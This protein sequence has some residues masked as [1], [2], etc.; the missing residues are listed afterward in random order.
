MPQAVQMKAGMS[1]GYRQTARLGKGVGSG[2][3]DALS[4]A[5]TQGETLLR[6]G[7]DQFRISSS[8]CPGFDVCS[9]FYT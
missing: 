7:I 8:L 3:A 1:E 9:N 4:K 6:I 5:G 2:F